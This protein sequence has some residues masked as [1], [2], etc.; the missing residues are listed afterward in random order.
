MFWIDV[1]NT[2]DYGNFVYKLSRQIICI[3]RIVKCIF[4]A[5]FLGVHCGRCMVLSSEKKL[6]FCV[7]SSGVLCSFRKNEKSAVLSR[8][9]RCSHYLRFM[10][11]M[12]EK[13]D[14]FFE[15][16]ARARERL[17]REKSLG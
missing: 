9:F 10:R 11:E 3:G 6:L 15:D 12:E 4:I 16:E 5:R 7:F 14:A 17:R 8:C 13:E 2:Q 1:K